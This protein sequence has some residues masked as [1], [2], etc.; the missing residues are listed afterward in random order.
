MN[1]GDVMDE[2]SAALGSIDGL[3]EFPYWVDK[4][5]PPCAI[6]G[7]PDPL[8]YDAA[9]QRGADEATLPVF[10]VASRVD[11]R[12]GRNLLGGYSNGS[13]P[14]SVKAAIESHTATAYDSARVQRVEFATIA[15]NGIDYLAAIFYVDV[16]GKGA[17]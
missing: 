8:T 10:V 12:S 1:L 9:M 14:T 11:S 3:R 5:N 16:I 6:V 13:G 4:F 2:L 7:W 17:I 15:S